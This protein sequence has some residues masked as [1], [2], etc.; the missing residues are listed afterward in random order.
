MSKNVLISIS[1]KSNLKK[2]LVNL[3]K[4]KFNIISSGGTY[5]EIKKLGFKC[6]EVSDFTGFSEILG[7]RVKTLHPKIHAGILYKRKDSKHVNQ[8]KS[9]NFESIDMVIVN[10]YPFE[11]TLQTINDHKKI[12]EQ[13]DIGGPALVRAAAKNFN[14]VVVVTKINQYDELIYEL[15]K[16]QGKTSLEFRKKQSARAF[17]ET[18]IYDT[19]IS[20][21]MNKKID[22]LLPETKIIFSKKIQNLRYGENPHQSAG[23]YS[24]ENNSR[25]KQLNGKE[26]SFNNY[27][28]MLSA[29]SISNSLPRNQG[30]VI[31]KHSVPCGVSTNSNK[32]KSFDEAIACDPVSAFGGIVSFNFKVNKDLAKRLKKK[33]L[34]VVVCNGIE[35]DA[36][37]ILKK[38][39]NLRIIEA[40]DYI[41]PKSHHFIYNEGFLLFQTPDNKIF[42]KNNFKVVSKNKPDHKTLK[43]LIFA[44]NIC[45]FVKSNAIVLAKNS[46]TIGIGSGQTSRLD[47]C[48]IAVK[49]MN[50]FNHNLSNEKIVAA[51]D[52]FFPFVDGIETLV[53][54]GV[55]A[56]IQ[57][58]GS[59]RDKEIIRFADKTGTVLVFSKTRHFKH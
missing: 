59:I 53:R 10:F 47:S 38:K 54:S 58:S 48:Q 6:D 39:K 30:S 23:I 14:D 41:V 26:L 19:L 15:K 32:V 37:K 24:S 36:L 12:I 1:D 5:R 29:L 9:N 11:K 44:F 50:K 3:K 55:Q 4:Y 13:I 17:E 49:K 33:F 8:M 42:S 40:K 7:G 43:S 21:Y 16:N 22:F 56:I 25:F 27:N 57:P 46:R 45:R 28:D 2:V 52:A 31:V 18:S 51:S 35:K 34:E 20:K